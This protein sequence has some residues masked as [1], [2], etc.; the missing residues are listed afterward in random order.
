MARL[1]ALDPDTMSPEQR[2]VYDDIVNG[3]R[4]KVQGPFHAWLRS[5]DLCGRAQKLGAFCRFGSS[6]PPRLSELAILTVAR[7]ATCQVEW[8]LHEPIAR[9]AGVADDV[10]EDIRNGR[11]PEFANEDEGA[12]YAAVTDLLGTHCLSDEAYADALALLGERGVVDLVGIVGYY[13]LVALTL[14][15]FEVPVPDGAPPPLSD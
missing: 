4:G 12:V 11:V 9:D 8:Y 7:H 14:N 3:P 5:P 6:L 13:I 1:P 15:G 10:I 2:Q